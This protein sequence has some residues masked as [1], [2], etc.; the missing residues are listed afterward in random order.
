MFN[1]YGSD[2]GE[3]VPIYKFGDDRTISNIRP[4]IYFRKAQA[5]VK[6][7]GSKGRIGYIVENRHGNRKPMT[8]KQAE[9]MGSLFD[10][11]ELTVV[12]WWTPYGVDAMMGLTGCDSEMEGNNKQGMYVM[13]GSYD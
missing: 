11:K 4:T 6:E 12:D 7:H 2:F 3:T 5:L 9:R 1:A 10:R 8:F 13:P